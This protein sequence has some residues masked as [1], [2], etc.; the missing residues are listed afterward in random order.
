MGGQ[1]ENPSTT[2]YTRISRKMTVFWPAAQITKSVLYKHSVG[3][4]IMFVYFLGLMDA[5]TEQLNRFYGSIKNLSIN[6]SVTYF[7]ARINKLNGTLDRS[8]NPRPKCI[9]NPTHS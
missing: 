1:K 8:Q 5:L 3:I 7:M 2:L 6:A 4:G 9:D